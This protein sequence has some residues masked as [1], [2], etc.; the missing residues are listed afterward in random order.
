MISDI[1]LTNIHALWGRAEEIGLQPE[2][3]GKFDFAIARAVASLKDILYLSKVFLKSTDQNRF[4]MKTY[5][6]GLVD[7]NPPSL[8]SFKGG[9]LSEEIEIA[10]RKYPQIKTKSID[11]TFIGSEQL[12]ASDKKILIV[13]F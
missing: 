10:K 12:I 11:L 1:K 7:P 4:A 2:Y 3:A 9:D 8:I 13:H 5:N 6:N